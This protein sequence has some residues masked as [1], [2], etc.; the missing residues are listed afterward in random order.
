MLNHHLSTQRLYLLSKISLFLLNNSKKNFKIREDLDLL[1]SPFMVAMF[2]VF[3]VGFFSLC[4]RR[5]ALDLDSDLV[6]STLDLIVFF[7]QDVSSEGMHTIPYFSAATYGVF[8]LFF[9]FFV[10]PGLRVDDGF[11]VL[12]FGLRG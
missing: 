9:I 1:F 5:V 8:V 3:S 11:V 2:D 7:S 10:C 6:S 12:A 4:F